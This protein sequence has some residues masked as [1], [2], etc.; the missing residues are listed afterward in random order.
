[1]GLF[2]KLFGS[3][4]TPSP[5][6]LEGDVLYVT[7]PTGMLQ[8]TD[9]QAL[10]F[11]VEECEGF[12]PKERQHVGIDRVEGMNAM[13]LVLLV[14]VPTVAA[15][16]A[17]H[18]K[19]AIMERGPATLNWN[20]IE[21]AYGATPGPLLR[22]LVELCFRL[23]PESPAD[24][25]G[26]VFLLLDWIPPGAMSVDDRRVDEMTPRNVW[27]F[28]ATGADLEHFGF[29]LQDGDDRPIE[30]RPVVFVAKDVP[31]AHIVAPNLASFLGIVAWTGWPQ[32][33]R[34]RTDHHFA[35]TRS[36]QLNDD[37]TRACMESLLTLPGVTLPTSPMRVV[38]RVQ[39]R[40]FDDVAGPMPTSWAKPKDNYDAL[41][42]GWL[43]LKDGDARGALDAITSLQASGT[44]TAVATR[45]RWNALYDLRQMDA[46]RKDIEMNV[47]AMTQVQMPGGRATFEDLAFLTEES[48]AAISKEMLDRLALAC[49][50]QRS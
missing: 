19:P 43:R 50:V 30:D 23:D 12:V 15:P 10:S 20:A 39:D 32:I 16:P 44:D 42:F 11:R 37:D 5:P 1:M 35:E 38:R 46:L 36:E 47:Q 41:R 6:R 26:S 31:P 25:L 24:A 14:D 18:P 13:G 33:D 49:G 27:P 8:T 21:R 2:D 29:L 3:K 34:Q 4:P 48:G 17:R 9:K 40:W 7:G 22:A 28:A 45:I